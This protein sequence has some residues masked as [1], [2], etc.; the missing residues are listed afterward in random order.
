VNRTNYV[1]Y[2]EKDGSTHYSIFRDK[3]SYFNCARAEIMAAAQLIQYGKKRV[4]VRVTD[5]FNNLELT[6]ISDNDSLLNKLPDIINV[7]CVYDG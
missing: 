1:V 4:V 3:T 7:S 6:A 5:P 2:E